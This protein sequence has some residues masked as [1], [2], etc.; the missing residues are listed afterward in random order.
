LSS[1]EDWFAA[2]LMNRWCLG[3]PVFS[4]CLL[5]DRFRHAVGLLWTSDSS[6]QRPLYLHRTTQHRNTKTNIHALS[7]IRTRD[8]SYRAAKIYAL[9]CAVIR[10]CNGPFFYPPGDM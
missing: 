4:L 10:T 8:P 9:C 3:Y 7:G 2:A 6:S 5:H 1:F